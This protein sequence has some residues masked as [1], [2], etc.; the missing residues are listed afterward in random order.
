VVAVMDADHQHDPMLLPAMLKAVASGECD[1]AVASRFAEGSS[2]EAWNA[3]RRER[4]STL[5]NRIARKLTGVEL[6][7]PMSGY[8]MLR[9]ET[10]RHTAPKLSGVGFKILLD[11]LATSE[12]RLRVKDFP[13]A[14]AARAAG[15]SKLDRTVVFEFLVG[16]YD[17]WLG[18]LIPTCFALFVTIGGDGLHVQH[19]GIA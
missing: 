16:L 14:F 7:D 13:L 3:P 17:Q 10:L 1:V 4:A 2:T 6:S 19:A 12:A 11:I 18:R 8:F 9:A 15:Q 5:A